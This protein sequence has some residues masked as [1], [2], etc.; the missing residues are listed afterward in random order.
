MD[1]IS[2]AFKNGKRG[3]FRRIDGGKLKFIRS[4]DGK[5][6]KDATSAAGMDAQLGSPAAEVMATSGA[7]KSKTKCQCGSALEKC[8]CKTVAKHDRDDEK[9]EVCGNLGRE[10][11]CGKGLETDALDKV[12]KALK[13]K[14]GVEETPEGPCPTCGRE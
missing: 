1:S 4:H 13:A 6:E 9:C 3:K 12:L 11:E 14:A 10:C 7:K 5:V 2:K 8:G